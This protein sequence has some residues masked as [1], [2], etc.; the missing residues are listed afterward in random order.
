MGFR[1]WHPVLIVQEWQRIWGKM[2]RLVGAAWGIPGL[3][4]WCLPGLM[5]TSAGC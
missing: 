4:G 2:R 5:V 1:P 3:S